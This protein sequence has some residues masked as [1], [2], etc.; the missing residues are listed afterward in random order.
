MLVKPAFY[1]CISY[2]LEEKGWGTRY[3]LLMNDFYNDN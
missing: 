1:R 2:H 3:P